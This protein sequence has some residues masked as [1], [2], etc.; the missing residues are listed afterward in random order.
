MKLWQLRKLSTGENLNEPQELPDN[1]GPIFGMDGFID[2]LS[3]LSWLGTEYADMGWFHVSDAPSPYSTQ[4]DIEWQ[5]AKKLLSDSDWSTLPDVPMT[6]GKKAEWYEYRR[7]LRE[8]RLQDGFPN[9][10]VWPIKPE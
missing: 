9:N 2:R 1:W 5:R 6:S 7:N 10:I 4:H 3:N 8:I